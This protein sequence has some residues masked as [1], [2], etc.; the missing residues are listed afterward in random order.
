MIENPSAFA[1]T[2]LLMDGHMMDF[3]V[4]TLGNIYGMFF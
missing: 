2:H 4:T 1:A 3:N